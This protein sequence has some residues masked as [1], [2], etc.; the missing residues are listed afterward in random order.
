MLTVTGVA[1]LLCVVA[2]VATT[3]AGAWGS[4]AAAQMLVD[5]AV[6]LGYPLVATLMQRSRSLDRG[7]RALAW[8]LLVAGVA[9]AAAAATTALALAAT[10]PTGAARLWAQLQSFLWV[11]GFVPL[12][13]LV[14]LLY[15]DG[16]LPGRGWRWVA[17]VSVAGTGLLAVGLALYPEAFDGG[18]RLAKLVTAEEAAR[19]LTLLGA[20]VLVPCSVMALVSLAVRYRRS[21]GLRRRQVVVL[22]AAAGVLAAVTAAQGLL[23]SPVDV[24]LQAGATLL[25]P[26]AIGIAVTRD[27]LYDLDLAVC[28]ALAAASLSVCL[29]GAYLSLV[30]LLQAVTP[31]RSA[32]SAAVAAGVVGVV[33]QPLGK[34]L[35]AAVDRV[36][37]GHRADPYALTSHLASRLAASGVDV[38]DVP[39]LV[40]STVV[41]DLR[42]RG[43]ELWLAHG[44][45]EVLAASAGRIGDG[46]SEG[47]PLRHRG[48]TVARLVVDPRA[49]EHRVD[50][51]DA[52]VL[53]GVADQAAPAV[54][55][56]HLH[57]ELQHSREQLVAARES[58]R[59]WL[60]H[61]LHDGLGATLAG[62]RLQVETAHDLVDH[63]TAERLLVAAGEGVAAAVAEVRTI[64]EGLR[65]PG[66][67]DLGLSRAL[68]A[69]ASRINT[70]DL[71]VRVAVDDTLQL[72][73]A[74]EVAL[75]RIAAEALAN[76]TRHSGAD[77][78]ALE[79]T[80]G[81]R[82][83][84]VVRDNGIGPDRTDPAH[85][86]RGSGLGLASIR[87]RAEEVGGSARIARGPDGRGTEVRATLPVTVGGPA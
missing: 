75:Y 22:L 36:Y 52:A 30:T 48:E 29:V 84:L 44:S 32:L 37:F 25:L 55:A 19:V 2:V 81:D 77:R 63:P 85:R 18:V 76:V 61:E 20:V 57:Q 47:F 11:P 50:A 35:T 17:G 38:A 69:L 21:T 64:C 56:L 7:A 67:D 45:G 54:A 66:I 65:P 68:V 1:L 42:L 6:G 62:L 40:C 14:P 86:T 12:L 10:E 74:V 58:E 39:A 46:G 71:E 51:R 4:A 3:A 31:A 28:R 41:D 79:V 73:P 82:V 34:R 8:V 87:R 72:D 43:A 13:T 5:I 83:E 33:L 15:P 27:R 24:L 9:A 23:P 26:V 70:P 59:R 80:A 60:R 49:G 53:Q 78:A 16:L